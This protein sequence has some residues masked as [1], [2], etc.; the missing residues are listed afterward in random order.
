MSRSLEELARRYVWWQPADV[1]LAR[2]SH[3]LCQ[4]MQ[5]GTYDDVRTVRELVGDDALRDAL[6]NAAPGILDARS[7]NF[8][9]LVLFRKPPPPLPERTLS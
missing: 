4:V 6:T 8:W 3:F 7:W 9:H 2:R 1:T 5:L